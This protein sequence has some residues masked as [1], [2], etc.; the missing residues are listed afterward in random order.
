MGLISTLIC[1][2]ELILCFTTSEDKPA[3]TESDS[4][5]ESD[6]DDDDVLAVICDSSTD[7]DSTVEPLQNTDSDTNGNSDTNLDSTVEPPHSRKQRNAN[8]PY[9]AGGLGHG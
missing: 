9:L 7:E 8:F 2:S 1:T 4:V 5:W 3:D 6:S